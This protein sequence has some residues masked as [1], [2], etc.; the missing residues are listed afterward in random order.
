[1][2]KK[3]VNKIKSA[4]FV[5]KLRQKIA[6]A[7]ALVINLLFVFAIISTGEGSDIFLFVIILSGILLGFIFSFGVL[8][9]EPLFKITLPQEAYI[10]KS[11]FKLIIT[12]FGISVG[13]GT[14]PFF[15]LMFMIFEAEIKYSQLILINII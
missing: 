2:T 7:I 3:T 9:G 6:F 4:L 15:L 14:F 12:E 13:I 1:M 5:M 11:K 8:L 10:K